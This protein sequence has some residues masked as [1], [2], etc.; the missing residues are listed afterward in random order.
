M[1]AHVT[2]AGV[3][4]VPELE[5]NEDE[6]RTLAKGIVPVLDQF[7][8]VPDPK[9]AAVIGLIAASAKVYG[10]RAYLIRARLKME[11]ERA[12]AER[13]AAMRNVTPGF[14]GTN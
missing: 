8:F 12:Q 3:T 14:P 7:D 13:D 2:L 5:L 9:I 11:A 1:I 4:N 6:S 10:P